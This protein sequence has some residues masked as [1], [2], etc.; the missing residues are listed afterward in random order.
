MFP[1]KSAQSLQPQEDSL[2]R[3]PA[4]A[5]EARSQIKRKY[6][7]GTRLDRVLRGASDLTAS[8]KIIKIEL[9]CFL[10][11]QDFSW[12]YIADSLGVSKDTLKRWWADDELGMVARVAEIHEDIVQG[13]IKLLKSYA[14]EII[15]ELMVLFRT[16][17]D[18]ALA[19]KVGFEL[20]DRLGLAKVNK[21]ESV[22]ATTAREELTISD[23]GNLL[24]KMRDMSPE[25]AAEVATKL[26]EAFQLA[27]AEVEHE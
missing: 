2:P 3:K 26:E 12:N 27:D 17:E 7:R 14:I 16:T 20:L 15:E 19:A 6:K 18:E 10:K 13:A 23:P 21:S 4:S 25:K 1:P 8:E 11:A 5:H 24:G 22:V 9:A